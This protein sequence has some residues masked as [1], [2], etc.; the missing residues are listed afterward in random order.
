MKSLWKNIYRDIFRSPGRF[1]AILG[2]IVLGSGFF[3]GL[4]VSQKAMISTADDYLDKC[5]FYD[6][7]VS[8][9][10]GLTDDD[11]EAFLSVDGVLSAEGSFSEDALISTGGEAEHVAVF[12]SLP[13]AINLPYLTEGRMPEGAGECLIDNQ[14]A[15]QI[16]DVVTVS[17]SNDEDT[18]DLFTVKEFTVVGR[19]SSPLYLNY[20]RGNTSLGTGSVSAFIYVLPEVFDADYY[21]TVYLRMEDMPSSYSNAYDDMADKFEPILTDFADERA[22]IRYNDIIDEATE[23]LND[24]IAEYE[25]ALA[26]YESERADAEQELDDAWKE[27]EDARIQIEDAKKEISYGERALEAKESEGRQELYEAED[28]LS[29]ALQSLN[30]GEAEY[31]QGLSDYEDG[32]LQYNE[33]LAEYNE[34]YAEYES[35]LKEYEDGL[36]EYEQWL[37][38][39]EDGLAEYNSSAAYLR[40]VRSQLSAA[41]DTLNAQQESFDTL[42]NTITDYINASAGVQLFP[43]GDSLLQALRAGDQTAIYSVNAVLAQMSAYDSSIPADSEALL[44]AAD[45]L[46]SGWEEYN[47]GLAS[48]D[49]GMSQLRAA[50][51]ELDQAKE[52][53]DEAK[54]QLD[55]SKA[56]LDD[57]AKQLDEAKAELEDARITLEQADSD[58]SDA[59]KELDDG[60]AEYNDGVKKLKEAEA[61]L[62][63]SVRK[64]EA[65]LEEARLELEEAELEYNDGLQE[66][67]DAKRDA[68]GEFSDAEQELNDALS[69]IED[70]RAEIDDIKYPTTYVLGRWSN[71][72]YACFDSDTTIVK[73]ISSV[74]PVFFFL[75]AA[76]ICTTT[77]SRMVEEQRAQLGVL[78]ALGYS[79]GRIMSKFFFYSCSASVLGGVIG[80]LG[81]SLVIPQIIWQAYSIMYTFTKSVDFY[82]DTALSLFTFASYIAMMLIVTWFSCRRELSSTP[83]NIIR[84]KA[85]KSGKRVFLERL[86]FIWNH[87][88][89]MW[90]VSIRNIF[91]YKQR[92]FMMI[93]G[94]AGCTAL[95]LTGFGIRDSIQHIV[96]YQ[97]DEITF[98]DISV[99]FNEPPDEQQKQ[100]FLEVVS[101]FSDGTI[102]IHQSS[103]T[104]VAGKTEK[105]AYLNVI[106]DDD[107]SRIDT[108]IDFHNGDTQLA[109]PEEGEALINSGLADTLGVSVGDTI[110]LRS[111]DEQPLKLTVSGVFDNYIY[112]YVYV[113]SATYTQLTGNSTELNSALILESPGSDDG[114]ASAAI[115]GMDN[116]VNVSVSNVLRERI[117]SMMAS[118]IY[119]VLLTIVSAAALA[120]IVIYNL[121]N[122]NIMERLREIATVKVLGFYQWESANYVL[123]ENMVLTVFG[124]LVGIPLGICLNAFVVGQIKVDLISFTP[125]ILFLSYLA[126]FLLTI[127]FSILVDVFMYRRLCRINTAEAL[128]AAE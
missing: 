79:R 111:D 32:L 46:D 106:E 51:D 24:G 60:W 35:G 22:D 88:S 128:K 66:Y 97:Y 70:A 10:L 44:L 21:T 71:V 108:F 36:A 105:A 64:A 67:L 47:S 123:R 26:E 84:P 54:V 72:G 4:R 65:E 6:F 50:K 40:S 13:E 38:E 7:S 102:F 80:I 1:L 89:F 73:S 127:L 96:D 104:A 113:S 55:D 119:I 43:D 37:A 63:S 11:V 81:G 120:F 49:L 115:L 101:G 85:P 124:A 107:I 93:I 33:G 41:Y 20:E 116:V 59:R 100:E 76:L 118:L 87:I 90:K 83:A 61:E 91:R 48:Y 25:D 5:A 82:F 114:A 30:D 110:T 18:Y 69:D 117:D 52:Q 99:T 3:V 56:I 16:G 122:I 58:L 42:L 94:I 27:L 14:S 34:N 15:Y 39:Y 98:Y 75:V 121:V 103:M 31:A 45:S 126:A 92:V 112:N 95:M 78:M 28:D 9:T 53:L 17:A 12:Y 74:F 2:I 68:E 86:P 125:R 62:D 19:V 29:K 23:E 57:A 77:I 8:T 109:F